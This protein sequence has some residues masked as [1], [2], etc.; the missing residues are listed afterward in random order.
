M[1]K[2]YL[3]PES[4]EIVLLTEPLMNVTSGEQDGAGVGNGTA[5]D[6]N[7]DLHGRRRG[8]WGDLWCE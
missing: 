5:G 6:G 1:K 4:I 7:P 2:R 8:V 3:S